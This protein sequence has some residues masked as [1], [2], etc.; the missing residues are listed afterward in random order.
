M[1]DSQWLLGSLTGKVSLPGMA[2]GDRT[3]IVGEHGLWLAGWRD[4]VTG[5]LAVLA[6]QADEDDVER[7]PMLILQCVDG[8]LPRLPRS[9]G[10][11]GSTEVSLGSLW[12][13]QSL[14]AP[15]RPKRF[16]ASS[17]DGAPLMLGTP[18]VLSAAVKVGLDAVLTLVDVTRIRDSEVDHP[19]MALYQAVAGAPVIVMATPRPSDEADDRVVS[20]SDGRFTVT[21]VVVDPHDLVG[22]ALSALRLPEDVDMVANGMLDALVASYEAPERTVRV[23]DDRVVRVERTRRERA[24]R[25]AMEARGQVEATAK[26]MGDLEGQVASLRKALAASEAARGQEAVEPVV[27]PP[28]DVEV[29]SA[30]SADEDEVAALVAVEVP[31]EVAESGRFEVV[32]AWAREH[33]SGVHVED[34]A[35]VDIDDLEKHQKAGVWV[36]TYAQALVMLDGWARSTGEGWEGSVKEYADTL[37]SPLSAASIRMSE[38]SAV[39]NNS[40]WRAKRVRECCGQVADEKARTHYFEAHVRIGGGRHPAPRLHF[41]VGRDGRVHVGYVGPHLPTTGTQRSHLG[42][43]R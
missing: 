18:K 20:V 17:W 12:G 4:P 19:L 5:L 3:H 40:T 1:S 6:A 39:R 28:V 36:R 14:Q 26:R 21:R 42:A 16:A 22:S 38:G 15:G 30:A 25:E 41:E 33:L 10:P 23:V 2:E 13:S 32:T 7:A 31:E 8:V 9:R 37:G 43:W 11:R 27:A 35:L 29:E 34:A 24:E